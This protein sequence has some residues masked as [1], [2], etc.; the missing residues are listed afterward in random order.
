MHEDWSSLRSFEA[1]EHPALRLL[2]RFDSC[3][4]GMDVVKLPCGALEAEIKR[5]VHF[6]ERQTDRGGSP[7]EKAISEFEEFLQN[8]QTHPA[9]MQKV[10]CGSCQKD[11]IEALT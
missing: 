11:Q 2:A 9:L 10:D 7:Y 6:I 8:H 3:V 4:S 1:H 5:L